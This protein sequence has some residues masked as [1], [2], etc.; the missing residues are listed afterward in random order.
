MK[1]P[2]CSPNSPRQSNSH[3]WNCIDQMQATCGMIPF[4]ALIY[5]LQNLVSPASSAASSHPSCLSSSSVSARLSASVMS[6]QEIPLFW[7]WCP[8]VMSDGLPPGSHSSA[9]LSTVP[10]LLCQTHL[11]TSTETDKWIPASPKKPNKLTSLCVGVCLCVTKEKWMIPPL[12]TFSCGAPCLS[13]YL[14]S[15]MMCHLAGC[16]KAVDWTVPELSLTMRMKMINIS[17]TF[18]FLKSAASGKSQTSL[19]WL[20]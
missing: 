3:K 1:S 18:Q 17:V 13:H 19:L 11:K 16:H 7:F 5:P 10:P 4:P 2:A 20:V 15:V 12:F 9:D 6:H 14:A 8:S